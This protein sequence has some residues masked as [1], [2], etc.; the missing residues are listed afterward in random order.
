[1]WFEVIVHINTKHQAYLIMFLKNDRF[2]ENR[3]THPK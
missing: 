3:L 2:S 1:M